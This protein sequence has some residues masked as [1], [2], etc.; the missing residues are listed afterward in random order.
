[1]PAA[2]M[3]RLLARR[4]VVAVAGAAIGPLLGRHLP[5]SCKGTQWDQVLQVLVAYR[6]IAPGSEW[7]LHRD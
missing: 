2:P 1:M 6:L 5:P 4:A 3:G 7:K